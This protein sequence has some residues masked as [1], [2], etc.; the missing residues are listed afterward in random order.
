LEPQA[1]TRFHF[2]VSFRK[3]VFTSEISMNGNLRLT[4]ALPVLLLLLLQACSSNTTLMGSWLD[5]DHSEVRI[6]KVLVLAVA[7]DPWRRAMFE[8]AFQSEFARHGVDA[9]MSMEV[10]PADEEL[11]RETFE[12]RFKEDGYDAV[13]VSRLV[14]V[15]EEQTSVTEYSVP[16]GY[17]SF[18]GYY[19]F[20]WGYV[21]TRQTTVRDQVFR[22]ETNVFETSDGKLVW[23]GLSSTTNPDKLSEFSGPLSELIIGELAKHGLLASR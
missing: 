10:L 12:K 20:A 8:R 1:F 22:V 3:F 23:N 4:L 16:Y 2:G 15:K 17:G 21:N 13:L 6:K 5:P 11:T 18:Y 14:D 7:K 19:S 9:V